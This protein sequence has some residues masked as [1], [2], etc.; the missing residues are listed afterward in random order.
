MDLQSPAGIIT[1]VIVFNYDGGVYASDESRMLAEQK[2][3][4]F[5]LGT[6]ND[7][8]N[9]IFFGKKRFEIYFV[10]EE[11]FFFSS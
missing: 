1:G 2:D 3:F 10:K 5:K 4:N 11:I 9:D 6:L 7:S 8:Y